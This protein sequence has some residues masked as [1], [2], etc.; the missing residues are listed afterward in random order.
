MT[1]VSSMTRDFRHNFR[2]ASGIAIGSLLSLF[3]TH[4]AWCV[5]CSK[6]P[7][8]REITTFAIP[9]E[10]QERARGPGRYSAVRGFRRGKSVCRASRGVRVL[11]RALLN[12]T[13][14]GFARLMVAPRCVVSLFREKIDRAAE[15]TGDFVG[16]AEQRHRGRS[17]MRNAS[18]LPRLFNPIEIRQDGILWRTLKFTAKDAFSCK[19]EIGLSA[20]GRRATES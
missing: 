1:T 6:A 17:E 9:S 18:G 14:S 2:N 16:Y 4:P 11:R 10:P 12:T 7:N 3:S 8:V 19:E 13:V 5:L 15:E 20:F